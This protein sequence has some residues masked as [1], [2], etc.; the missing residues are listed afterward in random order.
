MSGAISNIE[1][2]THP[3]S[4][5][6]ITNVGEQA[7][8]A[9]LTLHYN[10]GGQKYELQQTIAPGDQMWMNLAELIRGGLADRRG[11]NVEYPGVKSTPGAPTS[12]RSAPPSSIDWFELR[13]RIN[14]FDLNIGNKA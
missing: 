9:L 12:L 14:D 4:L 11:N 10:N 5:A 8:D 3:S 6:A 2:A 13:E 7:T 1:E